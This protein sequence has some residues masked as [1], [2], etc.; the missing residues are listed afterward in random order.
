MVTESTV[1]IAGT[2]H[3]VRQGEWAA[4]AQKTWTFQWL[5]GKSIKKNF[6]FYLFYNFVLVSAIQQHESVIYIHIYI[7]I[8]IHTHTHICIYTYIC[9]YVCI[10]PSLLSLHLLSP[11]QHSSLLQSIRQ[12]SHCFTQDSVY[13]A[14][15]LS[16]FDP[17]SP[18]AAVPT[19]LFSTRF[20]STIFL[21]SMY[22][23]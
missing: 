9:M 13:M 18:S 2:Q 1:F 23:R 10:C 6:F 22:M 17:P 8:Y 20:I 12:G 14:I 19:S 11:S 21:N 7:Y 15:L 4:H 16:Q 3:G 5:S